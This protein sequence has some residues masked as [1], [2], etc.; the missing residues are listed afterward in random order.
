MNTHMR[1][2]F[3]ALAL[4]VPFRS[5]AQMEAVDLGLSVKWASC[6]LGA[7]KPKD[8]GKFYAW[9][10]TKGKTVFSENNY[11]LY[12]PGPGS[13]GRLNAR[14]Y[15]LK[16]YCTDAKVG[17]A[18]GVYGDVDGKT[19]LAPEDDAAGKELGR[20]WRIPT[21]AER[22]ELIS[23][24]NWR[25]TREGGVPGYLVTSKKN[26]NSIFL[27]AAGY[28]RDA[29]HYRDGEMGFYWTA[30]V[31]PDEPDQSYYMGFKDGEIRPTINQYY[32][33]NSPGAVWLRHFG[34]SIR[35]VTQ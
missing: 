33:T 18:P 26:G 22:D 6:N 8:P 29:Y 9:G 27:P 32:D 35:P 1:T 28:Y 15:L 21:V 2:L 17:A 16:K 25:W 24:C 5:A 12:K 4:L 3:L 7:S 14:G 31:W 34:F 23:K 30:S 10:E 13:D 19:V 11:S 20:K